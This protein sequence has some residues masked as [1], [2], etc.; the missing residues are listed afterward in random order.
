[1]EEKNKQAK[2]T[3]VKVIFKFKMTFTT[4]IFLI[5]F[6]YCQ[7]NRA[8]ILHRRDYL[9][10]E[11]SC[12]V[13]VIRLRERRGWWVEQILAEYES[14]SGINSGFLTWTIVWPKVWI[15]ALGEVFVFIVVFFWNKS[16]I[17][18]INLIRPFQNTQAC[19]CCQPIKTSCGR[20]QKQ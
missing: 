19:A 12:R 4:L 13:P 18:I 15:C 5:P 7:R 9:G 3:S 2:K 16:S 20:Q 6:L 1:M 17:C 11:C 14:L 10:V 8:W